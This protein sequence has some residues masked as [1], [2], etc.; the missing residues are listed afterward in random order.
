MN[1]IPLNFFLYIYLLAYTHKFCGTTQ[2]RAESERERERERDR[3]ETEG[4][5]RAWAVARDKQK[6]KIA[7]EGFICTC[8]KG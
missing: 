6:E 7:R 8:V 5:E 2:I 4:R 1:V 3:E